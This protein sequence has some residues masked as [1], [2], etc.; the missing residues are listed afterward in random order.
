MA[1][2][3][4]ILKLDG[5]IPL[6]L[7]SKALNHF[8]SIVFKLSDEIGGSEHIDWTVTEL[9]TG[10][11]IQTIR[12]YAQNPERVERVVAAMGIAM[13]SASSGDIIPYSH[14]IENH[15]Q[16]LTSVLNGKITAMHIVA[17][18]IPISTIYNPIDFDIT[19]DK[20]TKRDLGVIIGY[21]RSVT[22]KPNIRITLYDTLFDKAIKC[23]LSADYE[24]AARK[25]WRQKVAVTGMIK[26]DSITGRP[27]D[28]REVSKIETLEES[29]GGFLDAK[30]VFSWTKGD[31]K[32]EDS[33]RRI[34]NGIEE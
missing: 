29:T 13:K 7:Y 26:R 19:D 2:N 3:E 8:T 12:G 4:I 5:I 30:G 33:I 27:I 21:V 18:N 25:V 9:R 10:S 6:D 17:G 24:N 22:D 20:N 14:D 28:I 31:E 34:R 23:Y 11:A 1:D 16:G 32:A 15:I